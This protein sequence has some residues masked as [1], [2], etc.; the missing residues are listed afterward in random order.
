M[1][2][3]TIKN[4]IV[5]NTFKGA[6]YS[7]ETQNHSLLFESLGTDVCIVM[8]RNEFG[9]FMTKVVESWTEGSRHLLEEAIK[10]IKQ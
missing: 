2:G 5:N 6:V 10:E 1:I 8:D 4:I 3:I 9:E 7:K